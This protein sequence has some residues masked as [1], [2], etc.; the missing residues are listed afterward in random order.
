MRQPTTSSPPSLCATSSSRAWARL[1][2]RG[3]PCNIAIQAC[4]F[5]GELP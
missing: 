4:G 2:D 1:V 3:M 5:W